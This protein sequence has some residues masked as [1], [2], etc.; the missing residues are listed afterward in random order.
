M[1]GDS[2]VGR[3]FR[4]LLLASRLVFTNRQCLRTPGTLTLNGPTVLVARSQSPGHK[5]V[6]TV[7]G[8]VA[9]LERSLIAERVRA[10]ITECEG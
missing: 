1:V 7:L 4:G 10:G 8:A 3:P 2:E 9:E 6:F 5:M